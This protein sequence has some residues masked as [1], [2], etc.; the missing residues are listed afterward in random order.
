MISEVYDALKETGASEEKSRKAAETIANYEN[1]FSRIENGLVSALWAT[2]RD[3]GVCLS[4]AR[5][6][7]AGCGYPNHT[8]GQ[9]ETCLLL[10]YRAGRVSIRKG[11]FHVDTRRSAHDA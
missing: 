8:R 11:E 1:R 10:V 2:R 6:W 4:R 9:S 5:E 3:C 7:A